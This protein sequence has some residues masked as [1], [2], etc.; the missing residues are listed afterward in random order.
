MVLLGMTS[1]GSMSGDMGTFRVDI[2]IENPAPAR[3]MGAM[4]AV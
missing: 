2:A 1:G 4:N 3:A